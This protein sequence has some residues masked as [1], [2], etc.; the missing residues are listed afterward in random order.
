MLGWLMAVFEVLQ[1]DYGTVGAAVPAVYDQITSLVSQRRPPGC[2]L[3]S[4]DYCL[5]GT[6]L[7][8]ADCDGFVMFS[9][10]PVVHENC[11]P[12]ATALIL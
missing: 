11:N 6:G 7:D 12:A 8:T 3:A 1:Y 4:L 2:D 10:Q 5:D 9:R